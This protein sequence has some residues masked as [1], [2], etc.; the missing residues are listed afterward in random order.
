MATPK[1]VQATGEASSHKVH[2]CIPRVPHCLSPRPNW[3]PPS[4][5]SEG[6]PPAQSGGG[7]PLARG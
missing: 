6:V 7:E 1:D 2:M 4:L 3:D 5:A